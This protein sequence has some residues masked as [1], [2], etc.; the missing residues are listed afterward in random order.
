MIPSPHGLSR[1]TRFSQCSSRHANNFPATTTA[2]N[3]RPGLERRRPSLTLLPPLLLPLWNLLLISF[4]RPSLIRRLITILRLIT[5]LHHPPIV[6]LPRAVLLRRVSADQNHQVSQTSQ[7][8]SMFDDSGR[9]NSTRSLTTLGPSLR[10]ALLLFDTK[11][12][13]QASTHLPRSPHLTI[14][15]PRSL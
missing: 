1:S 12:T 4:P 14:R 15:R 3:P 7:K 11:G 2:M 6:T 13:I 10:T 5:T 8:L 9:A